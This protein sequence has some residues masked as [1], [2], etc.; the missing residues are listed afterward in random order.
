MSHLL[1][2]NGLM[3]SGSHIGGNL[4]DPAQAG[5][6]QSMLDL[7][8]D[9]LVELGA[10]TL[11]YSGL[12]F[13]SASQFSADLDMLNRSA[14]AAAGRGVQ[15]LYHNHNW[16][17]EDNRKVIDAVLHETSS[18]LGL[19]PDVAWVHKAGFDPLD[20][21]EEAKDRVKMVHFKDFAT[22]DPERV[23]TVEFGRGIVPLADVAQWIRRNLSDIWVVAEQD[24]SQLN[25]GEAVT[26]N[27]A[28][29]QEQFSP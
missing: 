21:L 1:S 2:E 24:S 3:L 8:I 25:P 19:C 14:E 28:F 27:A 6:E 4:D 16:E 13:E 15:L 20:F 29:M 7:V 18:E 12:R 9:Y 23:D 5:E 26:K 11:M 22:Q 17:F 10:S